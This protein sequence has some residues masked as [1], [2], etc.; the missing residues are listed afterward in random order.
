MQSIDK[1]LGVGCW[2]P[3]ILPTSSLAEKDSDSPH[4]KQRAGRIKGTA[5]GF[6]EKGNRWG[7]HG[8]LPLPELRQKSR[9]K[10]LADTGGDSIGLERER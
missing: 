9:H 7:T 2:L 10:V 3:T 4:E 6:G 5:R 8:S 1:V